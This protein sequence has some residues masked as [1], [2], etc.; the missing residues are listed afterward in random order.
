MRN[1]NKSNS[2]IVARCFFANGKT[3]YNNY[4]KYYNNEQK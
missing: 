2:Q 4:D 1:Y 3:E